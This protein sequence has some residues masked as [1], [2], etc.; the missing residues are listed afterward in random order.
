[1]FLCI[2]ENPLLRPLTTP[3]D[4]PITLFPRGTLSR[5]STEVSFLLPLYSP[6]FIVKISITHLDYP[7]IYYKEPLQSSP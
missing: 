2:S 3:G 1:M 6:T 4:F 5:D 7:R